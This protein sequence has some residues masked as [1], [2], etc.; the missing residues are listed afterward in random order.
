MKKAW[1]QDPARV[2][3]WLNEE[4][5]CIQERAKKEK[6]HIFGGDETGIRQYHAS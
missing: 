1:E 4:Y 6:A 2:Q 5:P 3:V